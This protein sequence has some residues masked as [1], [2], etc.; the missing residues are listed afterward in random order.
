MKAAVDLVLDQPEIRGAVADLRVDL[1]ADLTLLSFDDESAALAGAQDELT[2]IASIS[3]A[4]DDVRARHI[5]LAKRDSRAG[6]SLES[7]QDDLHTVRE[8]I[9]QLDSRMHWLRLRKAKLTRAAS[10]QRQGRGNSALRKEL[11]ESLKLLPIAD[12]EAIAP[13]GPDRIEDP[14]SVETQ[15]HSAIDAELARIHM[16]VNQRRIEASKLRLQVEISEAEISALADTIGENDPTLAKLTASQELAFAQLVQT[17]ADGPVLDAVRRTLNDA[18]EVEYSLTWEAPYSPG[19]SSRQYEYVKTEAYERTR[20]LI[21][22]HESASI[23]ISGPRG[24]GKSTLI[25]HLCSRAHSEPSQL[26][27]PLAAP[28]DYEPRDFIL[29]AY[30]RF[31]LAVGGHDGWEDEDVPVPR[32][33]RRRL[34]KTLVLVGLLILAAALSALALWSILPRFADPSSAGTAVAATVF[35]SQARRLPRPEVLDPVQVAWERQNPQRRRSPFKRRV[36]RAQS[37][38]ALNWHIALFPA[39]SLAA[40]L[41][42][43]GSVRP[44]AIAAATCSIVVVIAHGLMSKSLVPSQT[45]ADEVAVTSLRS[46]LGHPQYLTISLTTYAVAGTL[47]W[48]LVSTPRWWWILVC[49][50]GCVSA[51][52]ILR[53]LIRPV[54]GSPQ[55]VAAEK[56]AARRFEELSS[57]MQHYISA[58]RMDGPTAPDGDS[59]AGTTAEKKLAIEASRR[60]REIRYQQTFS[61]TRSSTSTFGAEAPL[62]STEFSNERS[63]EASRS[64]HPK[65]FPE[66]VNEFRDFLQAT[67]S[68]YTIVIGIDELDKMDAISS[69]RFL[70]GIKAIFGVTGCHFLV[71]VS[72]DAVVEYERRGSPFK[73]VFDSAFDEIVRI[74]QFD[75]ATSIE[76]CSRRVIGLPRSAVLIGHVLSAGLPRELLRVLRSLVPE[77]P[78]E[79][80]STRDSTLELLRIEGYERRRASLH[81]LSKLLTIGDNVQS[82]TQFMGH[83]FDLSL[84]VQDDVESLSVLLRVMESASIMTPGHRVIGELA[85][86]ISFRV[87]LLGLIRGFDRAAVVQRLEREVGRGSLERLVLARR[88][89]G[90]S[91]LSAMPLLGDFGRAWEL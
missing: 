3:S 22:R 24:S 79:P 78:G 83:L 56:E 19:L 12:S 25:E 33:P 87:T 85:A 60:L 40:S 52:F 55:S 32:H 66:I 53:H 38:F 9:R 70:N 17:L 44:A 89:I 20:A 75:Y 54:P 86:F 18:I 16:S 39:A 14:A 59:S 26:G 27:I 50:C 68:V 42:A 31:C 4:I 49:V 84:D 67:S 28:V 15:V 62:V 64:R 48:G 10:A 37:W 47:S 57:E 69:E 11:A 35:L 36:A 61:A 45:K 51:S 6:A 63:S 76:F 90:V 1:D 72:E 43:P 21:R 46:A 88:L 80:V 7:L 13:S 73:S 65:T 30:S 91:P 34:A 41:I 71:S 74:D 2:R 5:A 77:K 8:D 58:G 29:Y 82:D 23:G 81:E